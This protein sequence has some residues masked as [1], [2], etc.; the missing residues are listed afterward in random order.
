M[1]NKYNRH[2]SVISRNAD[3]NMDEDHWL[4]QFQKNLQK[5]A[6]QPKPIDNF[7]FDQINSIMNNKSKYPSVDAAVED[8]KQRSGLVAF[9]AKTSTEDSVNSK[10]A[11]QEKTA[12]DNNAAMTK[13]VPMGKRLPIVIMKCPNI[14]STFDNVVKSTRGN[15][16]IP[17]IIDRVRSIHQNDVSDA[18]DWEADDL[19]AYVSGINLA[20]KS[21]TQSS[22]DQP[23]NLGS[24]NDAANEDVDPANTDAFIGLV[25]ASKY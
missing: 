14:R 19:M 16:S 4:N 6:V 17:A 18:K 10:V 22:D 20:E 3:E 15:L 8:M 23:T 25:P 12:S 1:S 21:K 2:Q 9:L 5:G 7:L 11:T 13:R 24:R